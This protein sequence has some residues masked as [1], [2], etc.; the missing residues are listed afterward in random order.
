[1]DNLEF[2]NH[3]LDRRINSTDEK[4]V[5]KVIRDEYINPAS[6]V[7]V[8]IGNRTAYSKWIKW[9]IAESIRQSKG[10][11]GIHLKDT[12]GPIP[13]GLPQNHVGTWQ[14]DKFMDWI[15]WAYQNRF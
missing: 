10:L 15:E 1:M 4:Y 14:P 9:E 12:N 7:I 8:L 11:L 5:M 3:K 2:Y 13:E 6:V